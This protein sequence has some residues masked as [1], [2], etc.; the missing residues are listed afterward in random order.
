LVSDAIRML[1]WIGLTFITGVILSSA[2]QVLIPSQWVTWLLGKGNLFGVL[3]AG[4]LGVPL[5]T[6]GG[7]A[8]PVLAGLTQMGTSPGV[9]L[10]FLLSGPATRVTA[11]AAMS[12]L[13]NRRALIVYIVYIVAGAVMMGLLWS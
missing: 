6:C 12:S 9:A 4:V 11:L 8:V 5:Y 7:S 13:L 10:A 1:E 3:A 2:I